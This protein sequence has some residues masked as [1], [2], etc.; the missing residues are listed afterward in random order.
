MLARQSDLN[1]AVISNGALST[2]QVLGSVFSVFG[3]QEVFGEKRAFVNLSD[4]LLDDSTIELF[5]PGKLV[6]EYSRDGRA[7]R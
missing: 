7:H 4:D 1:Y 5:H 6:L 2:A 3:S